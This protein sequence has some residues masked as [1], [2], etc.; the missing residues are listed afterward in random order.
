[1][2]MKIIQNEGVRNNIE[3]FALE[4]LHEQDLKQTTWHVAYY[5]N[6]VYRWYVHTESDFPE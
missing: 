2:R 5:Y 1:M 3:S 4:H 6:I